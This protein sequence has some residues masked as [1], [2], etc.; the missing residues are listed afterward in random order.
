MRCL[1]LAALRA[2]LGLTAAFPVQIRQEAHLT[3]LG[4]LS[5]DQMFGVAVGLLACVRYIAA[6]RVNPAAKPHHV[7]GLAAPG[8]GET[9]VL[10]TVT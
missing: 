1:A 2:E 5:D 6:K 9:T 8:C 7:H 3:Q 10:N 4:D